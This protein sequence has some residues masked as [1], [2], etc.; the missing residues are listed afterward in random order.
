MRSAAADGDSN[1][2]SA[3]GVTIADVLW[4]GLRYQAPLPEPRRGISGWSTR[5]A[6]A[7]IVR[8]RRERAW[9]HRSGEPWLTGQVLL[10][11]LAGS[12][13]TRADVRFEG[14]PSSERPGFDPERAYRGLREAPRKPPFLMV[15][16]YPRSGTTSLQNLVLRAFPDHVPTGTWSGYH[17]Q[18]FLW[19]YSKHDAHVVARLANLGPQSTRV[20]VCMRDFVGA[21]ASWAVYQGATSPEDLS[22]DWLNEQV[23]WWRSFLP[24]LRMP[25]VHPVEFSQLTSSTPTEAET[26][27]RAR[28]GLGES[29]PLGADVTWMDLYEGGLSEELLSSERRSNLP[30]LDRRGSAAVLSVSIRRALG[31]LVD[32]LDSEA[33]EVVQK[34][35][36]DSDDDL[37]SV[38][39]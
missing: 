7:P 39:A 25:G 14:I 31:S 1:D 28:M 37:R 22:R 26:V 34:A 21:A 38:D 30:S 33:A 4:D 32:E 36:G 18:L 23:H 17:E 5:Y 6:Y 16:G 27:L 11:R 20:L 2:R 13:R 8:R 19:S 24:C 29:T 15:S 35:L 12:R 10:E 9:Q 3:E